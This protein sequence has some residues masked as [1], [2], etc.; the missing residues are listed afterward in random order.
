M[1]T[2]L[3]PIT[4]IVLLIIF[5]CNSSKSTTKKATVNYEKEGYTFGIIEPKDSG[6][7][8]W[9]IVDSENIKYEPE[10]IKDEKFAR[11]STKKMSIYFKFLPLRKRNNC[12]DTSPIVLT[13]VIEAENK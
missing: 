6:N 4:L 11:F 1:K 12:K 9:V 3:K 2:A 10:N 7:C 8:S 13:E 5:S